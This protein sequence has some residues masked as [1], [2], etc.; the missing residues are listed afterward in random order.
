VLFA[1]TLRLSQAWAFI[2]QAGTDRPDR[3][4]LS[5]QGRRSTQTAAA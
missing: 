1:L 4:G 3:G 5:G 2:A